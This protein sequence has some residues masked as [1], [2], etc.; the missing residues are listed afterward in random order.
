MND[1]S[2][3]HVL[4]PMTE[5][6]TRGRPADCV[7]DDGLCPIEIIR[8]SSDSSGELPTDGTWNIARSKAIW[9]QD[10]TDTES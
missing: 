3:H 6:G 8:F 9:I 2:N 5:T 1:S 7:L 4:R 10:N